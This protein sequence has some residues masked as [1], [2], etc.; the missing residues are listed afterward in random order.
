[1]LG[2]DGTFGLVGVGSCSRR[3][4][5]FPEHTGVLRNQDSEDPVQIMDAGKL[6]GDVALALTE[7]DL[8]LGVQTVGQSRRKIVQCRGM[9][10]GTWSTAHLRL[11][12]IVTEGDDLLCSPH[13]Q[14][15]GNDAL[16]QALHRRA[17]VQPQK[18]AGVTCTEDPSSHPPLH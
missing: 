4:V 8:D 3:V 5:V 11:N 10:S 6:D 9:C 7:V 18:G 14:A 1:M 2:V 17:I 16:S 15:L 12:W 13:A